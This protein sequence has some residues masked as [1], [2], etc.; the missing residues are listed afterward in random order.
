MTPN[1][2][3]YFKLSVSLSFRYELLNIY[4]VPGTSYMLTEVNYYGFI[5]QARKQKSTEFKQPIQ[6]Y[7]SIT[8][9]LWVK[10]PASE[11]NLVF[12]KTNPT[13]SY[14]LYTCC[15]LLH[16]PSPSWCFQTIKH[17]SLLYPII[18]K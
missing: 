14:L 17:V 15:L 5:I 6:G 8:W 1:D 18:G 3:L 10:K 11:A 7:N 9:K 16:T 13:E 2:L 12:Y 4:D